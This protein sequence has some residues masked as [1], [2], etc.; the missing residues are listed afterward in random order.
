MGNSDRFEH[1][2]IAV[3]IVM[4]A[5]WISMMYARHNLIKIKN[6]TQNMI[7]AYLGGR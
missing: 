6:N 4:I 2:V 3:N 5:S 7:M 1:I